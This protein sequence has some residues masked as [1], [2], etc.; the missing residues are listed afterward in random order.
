[1]DRGR[2]SGFI[3]FDGVRKLAG[4]N[5]LDGPG[6]S[7]DETGMGRLGD[8]ARPGFVTEMDENPTEGGIS[9]S[10][11]ISSSDEESVSELNWILLVESSTGSMVSLVMCASDVSVG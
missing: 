7:S 2:G 8:Q 10:I 6:S 4:S 5:E 1:M 11:S 3:D 9:I